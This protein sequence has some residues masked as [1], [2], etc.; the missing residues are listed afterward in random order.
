LKATNTD[1]DIARTQFLKR[2][3]FNFFEDTKNG[4]TVTTLLS[5]NHPIDLRCDLEY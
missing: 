5:L 1:I 4:P 2:K 3:T